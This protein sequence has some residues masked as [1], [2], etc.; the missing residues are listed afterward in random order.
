MFIKMKRDARGVADGFTCREYMKGNVYSVPD[1]LGSS[2]T[3]DSAAEALTTVE[4]RDF[5]KTNAVDDETRKEAARWLADMVMSSYCQINDYRNA[6]IRFIYADLC[7][8]VESADGVR[9][10]VTNPATPGFGEA[11]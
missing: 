8:E 5:I 11:V 2:L 1:S 7:G 3:K 4:L 6:M 10:V 9:L